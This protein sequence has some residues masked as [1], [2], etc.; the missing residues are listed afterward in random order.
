MRSQITRDRL[1]GLISGYLLTQAIACAAGLEIADKLSAGPRTAAELATLAQCSA[2][3]LKRVMRVLCN[4]GVFNEGASGY[5]LTPTSEH[6]RRDR[7]G[8]LWPLA[9]FH[10]NELYRALGGLLDNVRSGIPAWQ[11][12][13]GAPHWQYLLEHA[14]RGA[15]FDS[16]MRQNHHDHVQTMVSA[17]D[18][19][20][21]RVVVDVGGADGS[22]LQEILT[23]Y[24]GASGILFDTPDVVKRARASV[25]WKARGSRCQFVAGDFFED[26]PT[27]GD[28][29][30]L[31]HILHDWDDER[32]VHLL[33]CCREAMSDDA[34]LLVIESL[35]DTE[36]DATYAS[37]T[38][39]GVMV[40]GGQE[41]ASG[42]Y[43]RLLREAGIAV[44]RFI[45]STT[46]ASVIEAR[47]V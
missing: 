22:L 6:L 10:G 13:I 16:L 19:S 34:R 39:L 43:E 25:A 2:T 31:R 35:L 15:I 40:I 28:V 47:A 36:R 9:V 33:R 37:L 45:S 5:E 23:V 42:E 4:I 21:A 46:H 27:G 29:Y 24:P 18:F 7:E 30:L 3:H 38:D 8:S 44:T 17:Y 1:S 11:A 32:C 20:A 41:R 26:I 14:D 12:V